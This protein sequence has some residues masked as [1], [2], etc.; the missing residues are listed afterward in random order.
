MYHCERG[1]SQNF[2]DEKKFK[3]AKMEEGDVEK[4]EKSADVFYEWSLISKLF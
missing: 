1:M 2:A 4:W 3:N